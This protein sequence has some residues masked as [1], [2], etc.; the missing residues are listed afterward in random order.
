MEPVLGSA[1]RPARGVRLGDLDRSKM[2]V[3]GYTGRR[4]EVLGPTSRGPD[5][6]NGLYGW[7]WRSRFARDPVTVT[8]PEGGSAHPDSE[9]STD[10]AGGPSGAGRAAV[11]TEGDRLPVSDAPEC[12]ESP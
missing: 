9:P 8:K 2:W 3:I 5:W 1:D 6:V 4:W 12:S 10:E 11:S 7:D